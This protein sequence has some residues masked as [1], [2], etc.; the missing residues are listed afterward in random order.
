[1][2]ITLKKAS[3]SLIAT[4]ILE[5]SCLLAGATLPLAS[6]TELWIFENKFSIFSLFSTLVSSEEILLAVI[7]LGF[8]FLFPLVK[9]ATGYFDGL[10]SIPGIIQRF[11][12]VDV[13][14]LSFLV[15]GGKISEAYEVSLGSGFYFLIAAL[16]LGYVRSYVISMA[17]D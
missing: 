13:F 9:I 3:Y 5:L 12:M 16:A 11:S 8:G 4:G 10:G 15:Y 7:V 6:I 14:L 1:M 17:R 2:K